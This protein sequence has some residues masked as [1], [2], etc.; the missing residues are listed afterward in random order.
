MSDFILEMRNINKSFYNVKVLDDVNF[1]LKP[2][3]VHALVGENGAGKS[4]LM[5]IMMG[6]YHR[7]QGEIFFEGKEVHFHT[8]REALDAG[9]SMIPQELSPI[10]DMEVAEYLFVG[11]E[12]T[13][14]KFGGLSIVDH[15][16]Q[17][18]ETKKLF[19]DANIHISPTSL[20]RD[21]SVAQVQLVEIIKAISLSS[22]IIIMDEPTS[23]ITYKE[24]ETL[25]D[26]I[27]LLKSK[28]VGIVYIS[29]KMD[30]IFQ[31]ADRITVLRDGKW[32]GTDVS[33]N[34]TKE[35]I[36]KMM[37]GREITEVFPKQHIDQGEIVLEVKGLSLKENFH[38]I[39]FTLR[40]GEILGLAGLVG[41]GRSELVES[42]FGISKPDSGEIIING[43][44]Q[45][46][47]HPNQAIQNKIALITEDRGFKGLNLKTS[48]ERNISFIHLHQLARNGVINNKAETRAVDSQIE[49][50]RIKTRSRKSPITSLS[51]GN[52]QKVVL[53]KWLLIE[54]DIIILDEPTRGIDVGAKRDIYVLIGEL[55]KTGKAILIIS[56]EIPELIGLTDRIIVMAGGRLTG[57][58]DRPDFTQESIM[59]YASDFEVIHE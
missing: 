45:I 11:R 24:V 3:E 15:K 10:L 21:L 31:I 50:L 12:I 34:F 27:R 28:G 48:V 46:F 18:K 9:L 35:K 22:K 40:R 1:T 23:A 57:E 49:K 16:K 53:A 43:K 25:F 33:K 5:K 19:D 13:S 55:A 41:A 26:Q 47:S 14:L 20:M 30:E 29:H 38:K 59:R 51:G 52:Q 32:V 7:D 8:P 36:I 4:T 2:G 58:I 44:P 17:R 39:N 42:I 56:S 37:V 6:I 54:P